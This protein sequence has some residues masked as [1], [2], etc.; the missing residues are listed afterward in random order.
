V[1]FQDVTER[2]QLRRKAEEGR[3][4]LEAVL[5]QMPGGVFIA[6]RSGRILLANGGAASIY[7]REIRSVEE[8][9]R[10]SLSYPDG[11]PIPESITP[12][13]GRWRAGPSAWRAT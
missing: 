3:A 8:S 4:R 11:E 9:G 1:Y 10:Y 6:D 2:E 13:P 7:G 5:Q 12:W